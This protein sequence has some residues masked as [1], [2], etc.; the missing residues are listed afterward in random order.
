MSI[1]KLK[2]KLSMSIVIE[3]KEIIKVIIMNQK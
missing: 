1:D 3:R 2:I